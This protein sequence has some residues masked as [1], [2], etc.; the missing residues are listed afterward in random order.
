MRTFEDMILD[1]I[2]V[3]GKMKVDYAIIGGVAVSSWGNPRTTGDLDVIA[4]IKME[5]IG[6]LCENLQEAGFSIDK[7]DIENALGEKTHFTIFD[8]DSEYHVDVK[9]VYDKFDALTVKNR[10]A[11]SYYDHTINMASAED[12]IAHKLLFGGYQDIRDAESILLRQSVIDTE[13]LEAVCRELGVLAELEA[14]KKRIGS[15]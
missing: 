3:L 9:G 11:I 8:Q 15:I 14:I 1:F 10:I 2:D 13:Y 12:T 6:E 4:V 5:N 7:E